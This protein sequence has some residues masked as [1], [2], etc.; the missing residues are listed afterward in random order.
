MKVPIEFWFCLESNVVIQKLFVNP[1]A[2][3]MAGICKILSKKYA[4]FFPSR[5]LSVIMIW[6]AD[7]GNFVV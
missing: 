2:H 3:T 7:E 1:P 6:I 4:G 5:D